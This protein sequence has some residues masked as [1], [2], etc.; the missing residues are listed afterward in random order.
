MCTSNNY[1]TQVMRSNQ[2][3][4]SFY[5]R[6]VLVELGIMDDDSSVVDVEYKS[7]AQDQ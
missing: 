6:C 4:S 2:L 1:S 3:F 5:W 7:D